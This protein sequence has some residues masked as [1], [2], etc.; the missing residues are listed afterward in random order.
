MWKNNRRHC[1]KARSP[2]EAIHLWLLLW[3][4]SSTFG[5]LATTIKDKN[6]QPSSR[7]TKWRGDPN[8]LDCI[9][10]PVLDD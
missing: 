8:S 5:L 7:A 1:E 3:I 9:I 6:E 4:A 2:N 10:S